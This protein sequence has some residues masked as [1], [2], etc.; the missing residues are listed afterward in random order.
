MAFTAEQIVI[1]GIPVEHLNGLTISCVPGEHSC[2][3]ISGYVASDKGEEALFEFTENDSITISVKEGGTLFS[4]ILTSVSLTEEGGGIRMEAEAKSR[5][6]LLDQKK[7]SRSFQDVSITYNQL[8]QTILADYPGSEMK[9]SIPD[10]PLGEIAIQYEETDWQFIK[11]MLSML[12]GVLTCRSVS[13]NIS[14]YGGIPNIPFGKWDYEKTGYRKEMG[15]YSYWCMEGGSVSDNDFLILDAETYHV[16]EI[17]EQVSV[18]GKNFVIRRLF[19]EL[20]K[21]LL[22]SHLELQK[23]EG[24]LQRSRY[25][26]HI[27]G[28][29]LN[30]KVLEILG[31]KI[32]VHLDIDKGKG[33]DVYWFPF[34]TLSASPDGS[35]WY[36]MPEKGDNVRIYFPSKHTKDVI[37]VSAVSSYDGKS[38]GVQDRMGSSSTKYLSNPHGQEMKLAADGI[39]LSSS[40]GAASVKIGNG[41]DVT[42]S[43]KGTIQIEAQNNLELSAEEA[44]SLEALET[45]VVTCVKGGAVKM[46]SD[47]KLLIQGTE[48][49]VN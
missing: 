8:F 34:S 12:N 45:A 31:T 47:G 20:K 26:M 29:A 4:G 9:L 38:G 43:A 13:N 25:P 10:K 5:S 46:I 11:R 41:G 22:L 1:T 2:L 21:G 23:K 37:A 15:E 33:K 30:G 3:N 6:I 32:K 28:V 39:Y 7:K 14:L 49:K 18:E 42:L 44:I 17:F 24:I 27:I 36:Y 48:V 16:P 40:K 35:G 19:C